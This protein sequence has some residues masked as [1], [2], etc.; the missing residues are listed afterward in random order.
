MAAAAACRHDSPPL[1]PPTVY[2]PRRPERTVAYQAVQGHLETWLHLVR[3]SEPDGDPVPAHVEREFRQYLTCGVLAHGFVRARC[4]DCGHDFLV[5]FSCKGRG[6]CS[7]CSTRRMAETAAHLVDHVFPEVPVRQ[8]VLSLPKRLRYFLHRDARLV[9]PVLRI[10][11]AEVEMALRACSPDAPSDAR[12]GAV[13]FVHR[14]GSALNAN[15]HFHCCVIDGLF[16]AA[17]AGLRFHPVC[18]TEAAI[19]RVQQRTRRR[20]LKLFERRALLPDEAA[21]L[22]LGW[23]HRGGFSLHAEVWVPAWDRAGLERL[24]RYCA[25]PIFAGE[26]L[27]WVEPD[28]RLIYHLPKPRPNGQTVLYLTPV[29]FLDRLATLVPPPRKHRH[30]YHGV[31]APH[32]PLRPAV[33]AYAGLPLDLPAPPVTPPAPKTPAEPKR[34]SP[35]A[36]LWAVLLARIYAVLPLICPECGSP[37]QLIAAVTEREPVQRILRHLGEPALPPPVSPARSPPEEQGFDWDLPAG[38]ASD[39]REPTFEPPPEFQFDQTVNW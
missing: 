16:S 39:G 6:V 14:F 10:F 38:E 12:F 27:A 11:L 26:R 15:L 5:A 1:V 3:S 36:Y 35:A 4:A 34:A 37:M 31:L 8:W 9:N 21:E 20:V 2:Q 17:E 29:E 19:A 13:T 22:M 32:S 28:E 23:E 33:T 7:S 30:R 24:L 25:R 18:L